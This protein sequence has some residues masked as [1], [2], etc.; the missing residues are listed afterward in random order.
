[1][2]DC[3]R[4]LQDL[5]D[6]FVGLPPEELLFCIWQSFEGFVVPLCAAQIGNFCSKNAF[7]SSCFYPLKTIEFC[8]VFIVPFDIYRAHKYACASSLTPVVLKPF[9]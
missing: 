9:R 7:Y 5:Q 3:S 6:K 1:M 2:N 4:R 8:A